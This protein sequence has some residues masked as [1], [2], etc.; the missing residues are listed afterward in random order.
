[1]KNIIPD[2]LLGLELTN[3][4]VI[5]GRTLLSVSITRFECQFEWLDRGLHDGRHG[6]GLVE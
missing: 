4:S 1:M 2:S 3:D 5:F 6:N